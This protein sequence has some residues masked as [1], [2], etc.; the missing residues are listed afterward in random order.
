[1]FISSAL[2]ISMQVPL[3]FGLVIKAHLF[4]KTQNLCNAY[5]CNA[6]LCNAYLSGLF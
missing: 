2:F 3:Y 6:Y 1:M 5:L 4:K